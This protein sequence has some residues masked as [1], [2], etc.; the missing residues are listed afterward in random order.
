MGDIRAAAARLFYY[1]AL[2][3][4]LLALD[5]Q[6]L[7]ASWWLEGARFHV[8]AHGQLACEECHA[9]IPARSLH[10]DPRRTSKSTRDAF[11]AA[12]CTGCHR[13]VAQDLEEHRHGSA[14][15]EDPAGHADCLRCHDP[16]TAVA[17]RA[18]SEGYDPDRPP[19]GQC[20]TCHAPQKTLPAGV[21]GE[22]GCMG[23]HRRPEPGD[24]QAA[25]RIER[26][27]RH[28][29]GDGDTEPQGITGRTVPLMGRE[30][31]QRT[32]HAAVACTTCH[33]QAPA[34]GHDRQK[35]A[36][37]TGCHPRHDERKAHDAH[38]SVACE[39]CHMQGGTPV[40]DPATRRVLLLQTRALAAP[41]Q[42][43]T[44]VDVN[45]RS[46]CRRCHFSG[47]RLGA[48][49]MVLPPKGLL[50]LPCH[51]ATISAADI[52]TR[53][54][55]AVF[56]VG[57]GLVCLTV[58]SGCRGARPAAAPTRKRHPK[59]LGGGSPNA[60]PRR[61]AALKAVFLDVLLQRRLFRA[62]PRRWLIHGLIF[63]PMI[64]RCAWGLLGLA[65]SVWAPAWG[66]AWVLLDKNHS[67]GE[68]V[69]DISGVM[70]LAGVALTAARG[71]RDASRG[72]PGLPQRDWP[73]L[74]LIAAVLGAGFA[75]EG[76]RM[77][78]TGDGTGFAFVGFAIARLLA[79]HP[80]LTEVYGYAWYLH[81][82]LT[83]ALAAYLPF[84]R[85]THIILSPVVL[86]MD[87]FARHR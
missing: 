70:I 4:F 31:P 19:Q 25:A 6:E 40:R 52:P 45:D 24:P 82:T 55:L 77:A 28:C 53:I 54:A 50:C 80:W 64:V 26:F 14:H 62:S 41:L 1:L 46:E 57:A 65:A 73:A 12:H 48:A 37:C 47:N 32:P 49:A 15:I 86:A 20:G 7:E 17:G 76:L 51:P 56:A 27:C 74:V 85:L 83:A 78:M 84:S 34:Y 63:Y 68:A 87:A 29:H 11:D 3:V 59:T 71:R 39:A 38:L 79:G 66:G 44:L 8:S 5:G 60:P 30:T 67:L 33:P 42:S 58:F 9:E 81:A 22:E 23:C 72:M 36:A 13:N 10:P 35:T 2:G 16:H 18:R 61:A 69:F 75:L 43:H 21:A